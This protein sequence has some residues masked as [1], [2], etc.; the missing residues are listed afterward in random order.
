MN[1]QT[2]SKQPPEDCDEVDTNEWLESDS[3]LHSQILNEDEIIKCVQEISD[4]MENEADEN[5]DDTDENMD[6]THA[7]GFA[8]LEMAMM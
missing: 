2:Y 7:E 6:P 5:I 1:L 4:T 8:V 3:D